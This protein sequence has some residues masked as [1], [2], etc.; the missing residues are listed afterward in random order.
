MVNPTAR[1]GQLYQAR[2]TPRR[3]LHDTKSVSPV[4]WKLRNRCDT[5]HKQASKHQ[6][7]NA[8]SEPSYRITLQTSTGSNSACGMPKPSTTQKGGEVDHG[9][10][11]TDSSEMPV[12]ARFST[13]RHQPGVTVPLHLTTHSQTVMFFR[14]QLLHVALKQE[15][16]FAYIS[17]TW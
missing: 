7:R 9:L 17:Q 5:L 8:T 1:R 6:A 3:K 11:Y 13:Y 12:A 4:K 10:P 2:E 14:D 15:I 16:S